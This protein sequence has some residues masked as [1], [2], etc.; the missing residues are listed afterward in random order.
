MATLRHRTEFLTWALLYKS[1]IAYTVSKA[2]D[3]NLEITKSDL[4]K[5]GEKRDKVCV[6]ILNI[7]KSSLLYGIPKE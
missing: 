5:A 7:F 1:G 6:I 3:I 4:N 2:C